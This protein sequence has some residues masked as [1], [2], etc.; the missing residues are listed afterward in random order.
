MKCRKFDFIG[1]NSHFY[2]S[3]EECRIRVSALEGR[4]ASIDN[5]VGNQVTIDCK[6]IQPG[7]KFN[8]YKKIMAKYNIINHQEAILAGQRNIIEVSR[9]L[10]LL[11]EVFAQQSLH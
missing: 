5:D 1:I 10:R 9:K 11:N 3:V 6:R 8:E 4:V 2:R 7:L